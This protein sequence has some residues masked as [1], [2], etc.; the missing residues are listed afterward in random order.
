MPRGARFEVRPVI[1][2]I[3]A[4]QTPELTGAEKRFLV[5]RGLITDDGKLAFPILARW[6][7]DFA[8]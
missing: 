8:E 4:G 3:V 6:L 2:Q 1:E 5:R 7:T